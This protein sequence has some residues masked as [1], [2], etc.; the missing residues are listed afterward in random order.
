[1]PPVPL[2][3]C[4]TGPRTIAAGARLGDRLTFATGASA[5]R[6][7][8]ALR[9]ARETRSAAGLDPDGMPFGASF[10]VF[11]HPSHAR[12]R[13]L[14]AGA[15][16]SFAHLATMLGPVVGPVSSGQRA[17]LGALRDSYDMDRHLHGASPQ[18]AVLT[19]EVIDEFAVA[20]P[21]GHCVERLGELRAL[22]VSKFVFFGEGADIDL[23]ELR[24]SRARI[25][26]E[27]LP[28]LREAP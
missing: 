24:A 14:I 25:A 22:G 15:V 23:A 17:V 1:V 8:W 21:V 18:S 5:S 6:L 13:E 26:E 10:P 27:L 28:A 2:E 7:E 12:A 16:A 20:G 9:T 3:V 11:V 4:A 19:D